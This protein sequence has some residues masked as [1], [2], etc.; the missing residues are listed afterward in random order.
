M[1]AATSPMRLIPPTI[2]TPTSTARIRPKSIAPSGVGEHRQHG[3]R[4]DLGVAWFDWN[5]LPP[6]KLPP[7]HMKANITAS[8]LSPD[9]TQAQ[10][11]EPVAQV[12]HG[13]ARHVPVG[14]PMMR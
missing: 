11:G 3:V 5:M 7:M 12:V 13:A 6:P 9:A 2:T 10:F 1:D 14:A 4:R 8:Q